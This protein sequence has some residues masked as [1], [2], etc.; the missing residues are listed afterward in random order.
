MSIE[1]I[2]IHKAIDSLARATGAVA[3]WG[4]EGTQKGAPDGKL[5]LNINHK[6]YWFDA[7]V[8]KQVRNLH[9]ANLNELGKKYEN[10]LLVTEVVYPNI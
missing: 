3:E 7:V 4:Q 5:R 2:M 1:T 8:K 9:L 10:L 6:E